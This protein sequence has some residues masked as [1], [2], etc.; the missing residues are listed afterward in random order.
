MTKLYKHRAVQNRRTY[1][2]VLVARNRY[3][4]APSNGQAD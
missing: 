4:G 2:H 3:A 1:E